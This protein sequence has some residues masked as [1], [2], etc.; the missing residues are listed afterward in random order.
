MWVIRV[1]DPR[2]PAQPR[3]LLLL[4]TFILTRYLGAVAGSVTAAPLPAELAEARTFYW[5]IFLLDL[6]VVV[7][8][9]VAAAIGLFRGAPAAHTALYAV[10][11]WYALV[12]PSVAAMSATMVIH[13]D[14]YASVAQTLL[15]GLVSVVFAALTAWIYAPLLRARP[16]A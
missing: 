11:L 8:A 16:G 3:T 2:K 10:I 1:P 9:T 15:L 4:A 6:G 13:G 5:S 14:P 12:P 7:P